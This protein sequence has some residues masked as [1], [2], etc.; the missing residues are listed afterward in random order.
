MS[1]RRRRV[2]RGRKGQTALTSEWR[3]RRDERARQRV[4]VAPY[5][6]A[7]EPELRLAGIAAW[8]KCVVREFA[9]ADRHF[10]AGFEIGAP[11][12]DDHRGAA[13]LV[14]DDG[15][16]GLDHRAAR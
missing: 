10:G 13:V 2:G 5:V 16:G 6:G 9:V 11:R 1:A 3:A 12:N 4:A 15:P 8:R 14:V 7:D